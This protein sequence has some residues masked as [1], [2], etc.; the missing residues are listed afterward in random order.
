MKNL[1]KWLF[2]GSVLAVLALGSATVLLAKPNPHFVIN[3]GPAAFNFALQSKD[4]IQ[5]S[6]KM[7]T[8]TLTTSG[9]TL[10]NYG[11]VNIKQFCAPKAS[12]EVDSAL[13]EALD[14]ELLSQGII[15]LL[16]QQEVG[17]QM[18]ALIFNSAFPSTG[19]SN[20]LNKVEN[21]GSG[22]IKVQCPNLQ[23][24]SVSNRGAGNVDVLTSYVVSAEVENF[25]VGSVYIPNVHN[26]IDIVSGGTGSVAVGEAAKA[27]V[28]LFGIG[29]VSFKN[30]P[31]ITSTIKGM[32]VIK[33]NT[34]HPYY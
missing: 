15:K 30:E 17:Q 25:G 12:V 14:Q 8:I 18:P 9:D 27:D 16:T 22:H 3:S 13:L 29:T 33:T 32:G 28:K 24:I 7:V 20:G 23:H 31:N 21:N 11:T 34:P 1:K 6:G 10:Q 5:P 4:A 2:P 19:Q 26:K